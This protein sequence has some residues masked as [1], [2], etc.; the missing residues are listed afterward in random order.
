MLLSHMVNE[1]VNNI[2]KDCSTVNSF[3]IFPL[4]CEAEHHE[5][6][7]HYRKIGYIRISQ[8]PVAFYIA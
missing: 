5:D 8:R 4:L 1:S 3:F 6:K 2:G 7:N